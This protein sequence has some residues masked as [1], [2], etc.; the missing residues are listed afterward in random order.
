MASKVLR[1]V[2][3]YFNQDDTALKKIAKRLGAT[4]SDSITKTVTH[5][6][7]EDKQNITRK[8]Q[9]DAK[10]AQLV[11]KNWIKQ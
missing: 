11:N 9:R 1:D 10:S 7:I 4:V 5:V 6:I 3:I 8:M 2:V